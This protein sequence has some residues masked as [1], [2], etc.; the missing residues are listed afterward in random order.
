[1]DGGAD[2]SCP[3]EK[4]RTPLHFAASQGYET[5]GTQKMTVNRFANIEWKYVRDNLQI[6]ACFY[7]WDRM[8]NMFTETTTI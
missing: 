5:I 7:V 3:D 1:M 2:P 6:S 4:K 8:Q